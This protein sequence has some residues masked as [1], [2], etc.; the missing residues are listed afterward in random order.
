MP[1]MEEQ[2]NALYEVCSKDLPALREKVDYL[3]TVMP[4]D[5]WPMPT[6]TDLFFDL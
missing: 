2:A 1:T 3:E 5:K 6:Y 4:K